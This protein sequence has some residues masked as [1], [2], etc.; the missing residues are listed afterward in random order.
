MQQVKVLLADDDQ[1]IRSI[2]RTCLSAANFD[3]I[4]AYDG[5][6]ALELAVEHAGKIQVVVTDLRMPRMDGLVLRKRLK[7]LYR[8][9]KVIV[10]SGYASELLSAYPDLIVFEKPVNPNLVVSKI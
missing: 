10:L 7:E 2:L 6:N 4:E 8:S 1:L 5:Q 3:V 9:M